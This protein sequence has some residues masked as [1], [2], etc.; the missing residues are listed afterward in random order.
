MER[1]FTSRVSGKRYFVHVLW[2]A[3]GGCLY[4][5]ISEDPKQRLGPH[6]ETQRGGLHGIGLGSWSGREPHPD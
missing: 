3:S 1:H 2:S 5:G 6:N 4:I